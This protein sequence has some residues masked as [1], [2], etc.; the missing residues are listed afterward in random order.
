MLAGI[1]VI[2]A[3]VIA[4]N[5]LSTAERRELVRILV[6]PERLKSDPERI[7]NTERFIARY[8][9]YAPSSRMGTRMQ[10]RNEILAKKRCRRSSPQ[11]VYTMPES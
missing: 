11:L 4:S 2:A 10:L 1:I 9:D 3:A 6:C 7:R 8:A 5:G